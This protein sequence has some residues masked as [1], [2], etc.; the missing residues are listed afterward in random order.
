[1]IAPSAHTETAEIPN[2][3][4]VLGLDIGDRRIGIAISDELRNI[5][6]PV[7]T[8]T[9]TSRRYDLRYFDQ[10]LR[11]RPFVLIIAGLPLYPSGDRSP[12]AE[13][14]QLFAEQLSQ[15]LSI[16]V[17]MWDERLSTSEA[18]RYL[19]ATGRPGSTRREV[20][21]QVAAVLILESWLA[22]QANERAR[23]MIVIPSEVLLKDLHNGNRCRAEV[24]RNPDH[25]V[26][27]QQQLEWNQY[28]EQAL[29][30]RAIK[31]DHPEWNWQEK[32]SSHPSPA[33]TL[34]AL[35]FLDH[36]QGCLLIATA[37]QPSRIDGSPLLYVEYL[38]AA[39]WN[40]PFYSGD[41]ARYSKVGIGLLGL[42]VAASQVAG[43]S[44][45]LA[46]HTLTRAA[47]FYK[48]AGFRNL[49][50]DTREGLDYLELG[51]YA[52]K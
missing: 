47:E 51:E 52:L 30:S 35:R 24:L 8:L 2:A 34:Y 14:A 38:E 20:I 49:G 5:A 32:V 3:G 6:Q 13:K 27:A 25:F 10:L 12:Q 42:A 28:K 23:K 44:G 45:R 46:L 26:I 1:M 4:R 9:R 17:L 21:D 15:H 16:P 36:I 43:C 39:P 37:P 19:D 22:A 11:K 40:L 50:Y 7:A 48:R 41:Q 29:S 33:N 31:P 18:H